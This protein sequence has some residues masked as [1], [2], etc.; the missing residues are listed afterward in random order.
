V[1]PKNLKKLNESELARFRAEKRRFCLPVFQFDSYVFYFESIMAPAD[2]LKLAY[3]EA[4]RRGGHRLAF[5]FFNAED[6]KSLVIEHDY[7]ENTLGNDVLVETP[8][9]NAALKVMGTCKALWMPRWY[10]S[11]TIYSLLSPA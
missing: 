8:F 7:G 2:I 11:S 10:T 3:E 9:G 4:E 6:E 5:V 1:D